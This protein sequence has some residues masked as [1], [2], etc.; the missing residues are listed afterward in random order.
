[1]YLRF[2]SVIFTEQG[3]AIYGPDTTVDPAHVLGVE[4]KIHHWSSQKPDQHLSCIHMASGAKVDVFMRS[5]RI[6]R[7][8][9]EALAKLAEDRDPGNSPIVIIYRR[10]LDLACER[11]GGLLAQ[12]P[13]ELIAE[14]LKLADRKENLSSL[15]VTR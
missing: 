6:T 5:E 8:V 2:P 3:Y 15:Q 14:L 7:A 10:A 4:A 9:E 13:E 12:P 1:M 11:L